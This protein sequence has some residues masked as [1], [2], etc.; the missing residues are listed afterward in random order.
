[1]VNSRIRH[2]LSTTNTTVGVFISKNIKRSRQGFLSEKFSKNIKRSRQGFLSEKLSKNIKRLRHGFLSEKLWK[3]QNKVIGRKAKD[4]KRLNQDKS[5]TVGVFI[6]KNFKRSRQGFLSE[7][8]R[9]GFFQRK[10]KVKPKQSD[11]QG[12]QGSKKLLVQFSQGKLKDKKRLIQNK[13]TA[14]GVFLVKTLKVQGRVFS[15]KS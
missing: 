9:S 10:V 15:A 6:S 11:R 7:K 3:S 14:A 1:M 13:S 4:K 12:G 2:S 8:L 5:T